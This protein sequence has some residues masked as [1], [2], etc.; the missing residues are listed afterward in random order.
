MLKSS[1][2]K[3]S[4]LIPLKTKAT[5][6]ANKIKTVNIDLSIIFNIS[7]FILIFA[8][9]VLLYL[10]LIVESKQVIYIPKGSTDYIVTY[11]DKNK[12]DLN[13]IDKIILKAIGYPQSG[14]IDLKSTKMSKLDFLYKLTT[15]KA[16]LKN[17]TLI[18]GETYFFFLNEVAKKLK[19]SREKLF[20]YY[21]IYKYKKD[22]NILAQ[23]Y[24][25]PIGMDEEELILYLINYTN[26]EYK[27][28]SQKIFGEFNKDNWF[29][30]ITIA[31]IIQKE[32]ASI[33]EMIL[34]SSVIYNR[35]KEKMKLQMDGT[36]NYGK[37]SHTKVTPNM[38]K[39]DTSNYNTYKIYGIPDNPICA[40]EFS[41]IKAAIFPKNTPYLYFMKSSDGKSHTFTTNYKNHKKVIKKVK[42]SKRKIK[43][44][45]NTIKKR[46]KTKTKNIKD[47]W[48]S[49][50]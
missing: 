26:R 50:Y 49:V 30:Y 38:I 28:Y 45:I 34:V 17:I 25:L 13:T 11:L 16:A 36:L 44:K 41:S 43:P 23:T 27:K 2:D 15:S 31:S 46:I 21:D 20:T 29:K 48:K 40:V 32:A 42:Q 37:Y 1:K 9:T 12:Y 5:N 14:W 33:E 3:V 8:I 22:G 35:L 39:N 4:I 7:E 18:P 10:N 19:I 24:S 6:I 47:L